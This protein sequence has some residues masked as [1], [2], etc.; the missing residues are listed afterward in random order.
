[1]EEIDFVDV[2]TLLSDTQ[3]VVMSNDDVVIVAFRG[4]EPNAEDFITDLGVVRVPVPVWSALPPAP[5]F[6]MVH[7]GFYN[8]QSQAYS[9]VKARI[10]SH[11]SSG[12]TLWLTGHS[13]GA[14]LATMVAY[15]LEKVD[16]EMVWGVYTYGS[17]RTG[18][19]VWSDLYN[20]MRFGAF[21][22][23]PAGDAPNLDLGD[24]TH[25]WVN[26]TDLIPALPGVVLDYRH[27]GT[28]H[29]ID[30]TG[31][32]VA[33]TPS[34]VPLPSS[35]MYPDGDHYGYPYKIFHAMPDA[36]REGL[37]SPE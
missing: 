16:E 5:P 13:L 32:V 37:P 14:A 26:N 33:E 34:V 7:S 22:F 29:H 20:N 18:D 24:K 19:P 30:A 36:F 17:P 27:V 25:R 21:F 9:D 2:T 31:A 10:D 4:T 6:P 15:N 28:L 3:A 11:M 23:N 12:K 35:L 1:M 8:A